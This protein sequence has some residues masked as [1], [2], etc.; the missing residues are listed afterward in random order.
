MPSHRDA[1][2]QNA[3]WKCPRG[4]KVA[5]AVMEDAQVRVEDAG[6]MLED[7]GVMLEDAGGRSTGYWSSA[8][9]DAEVSHGKP[10]PLI[11]PAR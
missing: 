3:S 10:C 1:Q 11:T 4:E 5:W 2:I 9:S 8:A 7:A 6:V